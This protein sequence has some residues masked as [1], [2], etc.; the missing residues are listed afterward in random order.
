MKLHSSRW[1]AAIACGSALLLT[2]C[3][4]SGDPDTTSSFS[5]TSSNAASAKAIGLADASLKQLDNVLKLAVLSRATGLSNTLT[6]T[7]ENGGSATIVLTAANARQVSRGDNASISANNCVDGSD[8][9]NGAISLSFDNVIGTPSSTSAW[10]AA[11]TVTFTNF[12]FDEGDEANTANGAL[13]L[14][15]DQVAARNASFSLTGNEV[16]LLSVDDGEITDRRLAGFATSGSRNGEVLTYRT[17]FIL[18]GEDLPRLGDGPYTV[19]TPTDFVQQEG[20]NPNQGVLT[21]TASDSSSLTLTAI[22]EENVS[23]GLD[24]NGD[25]TADLSTTTTWDNLEDQI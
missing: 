25:G 6:F 16:Q 22:D 5:P 19:A 20:S 23:L 11:M 10:S 3:G 15:Y 18:S 24:D 14:V 7:C 12:S 13:T 4:G 1:P 21:V 9:A 2:A 17:A 8:T